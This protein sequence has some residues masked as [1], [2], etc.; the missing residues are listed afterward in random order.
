MVGY[1]YDAAGRLWKVID[2]AGGVTEYTYDASHRMLTIKDARGI[3]FLTNEY[4]AAGRVTKQTQADATTYLFA[5]TL[6]G[7][8]QGHADGPHESRAATCAG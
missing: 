3:V 2:A 6:D 1:V 7:A 5:Y 4:N 8:R